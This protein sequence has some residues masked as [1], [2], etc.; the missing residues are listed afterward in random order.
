[1]GHSV[2]RVLLVVAGLAALAAP[3]AAATYYG[4]HVTAQPPWINRVDVY[5]ND[6]ASHTFTLSI[7]NTSGQLVSSTEYPVSAYSVTSVVLPADP[8]Y[9][10]APGEIVLAPVEGTCA[11]TAATQRV[12]PKLSYR[13]GD[14]L[15]LCE[16]FMQERLT[17]EY[18]LPNT[19]QE[20]FIGT[21][22]AV[23]NPSDVPLLVRLE[24]FRLGVRVGDTG[25]VAIAPRTKLV[26]IS[27]GLWPGVGVDDFDLVRISSDEVLFPT[28][29]AITWDQLN[30]RHVFFNAAPTAI[31]PAFQPGD[32][33]A[34]DSIVGDLMWVPAGT[35]TQGSP[36]DEP[37]SWETQFTHTLTRNLA[38]MATEVTQGMWAALKAEQSTLPA[39]SSEHG[40]ADHPVEQV[41]WYEA[42][43]FANLLSVQ[44]GLTRC[45]YTD[46]GFTTPVTASNY[47]TGPFY[48][49]FNANG[50]RLPT[51]GEWE[52][53][54]RAGTTMPFWIAEPNYNDGNCNTCA[55]GS[56]PSLESAVVF[57]ADNPGSTADAGT[58]LPNPWGLYDTHGNVYEWCWDW[59]S[60]YPAGSATSYTGPES[61][62]YRILRGGGWSSNPHSCLSAARIYSAPDNRVNSLGFRL[63]RGL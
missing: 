57:C 37:C 38:V 12:R 26:S 22:I 17:W 30:D 5:N 35:F 60:S 61:G 42:V 44:Q 40:G 63:V 18:V 43:L 15:S 14:S 41:T 27:E 48:C 23:M 56:L 19:I 46:A 34:V 7:W 29:M 11:V 3:V 13:Y 6:G 8:G 54:C 62:S 1:M 32:L 2:L 53:F 24:A 4:A 16:F 49:N 28:P 45:Y 59:M 25:E 20:H 50:F 31:D 21:G 47:T 51:E 58:K 52:Y 33:Y 39:N 10:P 36:S 55:S 9:T